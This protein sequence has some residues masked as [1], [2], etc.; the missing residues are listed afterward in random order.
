MHILVVEDDGDL[1]M[2]IQEVL[3]LHNYTV[4]LAATGKE[5]LKLSK[6]NP[7]IKLILLDFTLPDISA[8]VFL[9]E[10]SKSNFTT[11]PKI[12]LA[13]G[14]DNI[15]T[16]SSELAVDAF[17]KKPFGVSELLEMVRAFCKAPAV[18]QSTAV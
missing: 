17:I 14:W 4:Y 10:L 11:H 2:F 13:S 9:S 5:A 6:T 15:A 3:S 8:K 1:G 12:I 7:L 18:V 16:L